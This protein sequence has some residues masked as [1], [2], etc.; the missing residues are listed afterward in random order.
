MREPFWLR[1]DLHVAVIAV[2]ILG[3]GW[4]VRVEGAGPATKPV[5]R[6]GVSIQ[7]PA[8]WIVAPAAGA[9]VARGEDAV[10]R[11]ELRAEERPGELVTVESALELERAQRFGPL[12]QRLSTERREA[13]GRA[14]VRTTFGYAFKPS[15][16]HA[17][18]LASA[19]EYATEQGG[20]L[21]VVTLHAP[22]ERVAALERDVLGTLRVE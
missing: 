4:L 19:V 20:R 21:V 10:T 17:P 15:S 14:W 1:H 16:N 6:G 22:E 11:V 8:D 12:Y 2:A 13:A 9:T 7:V 5:A 18:R 3:L